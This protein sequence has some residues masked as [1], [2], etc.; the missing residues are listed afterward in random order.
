MPYEKGK[1]DTDEIIHFLNYKIKY[2]TSRIHFWSILL[3]AMETS[4]APLIGVSINLWGYN[5]NRGN[6]ISLVLSC[7]SKRMISVEARSV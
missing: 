3:L 1:E 4:S 7:G 2:L 5:F 6:I